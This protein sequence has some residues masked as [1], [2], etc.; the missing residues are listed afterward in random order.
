M[1]EQSPE[2]G[3]IRTYLDWLLDV[4][5]DVRTEDNLEIA[6]ARRPAVGNERL[7]EKRHAGTRRLGS[8]A[9]YDC[10][11]SLK[12]RQPR[13]VAILPYKGDVFGRIITNA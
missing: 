6:D 9:R 12:G 1:S 8:S 4:P 3:W 7:T 10:I 5:W 2:M 11:D 13:A